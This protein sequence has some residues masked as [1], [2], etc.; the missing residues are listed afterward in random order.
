MFACDPFI[1]IPSDERQKFDSK[2][3]KCIFL[4]YGDVTY[5]FNISKQKVIF[6]RHDEQANDTSKK[7]HIDIIDQDYKLIPDFDINTVDL[8]DTDSQTGHE[9]PSRVT[10]KV[11]ESQSTS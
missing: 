11:I 4:G 2:T 9:P 1:P 8:T 7:D 5:F 10:E 3:L 6:S